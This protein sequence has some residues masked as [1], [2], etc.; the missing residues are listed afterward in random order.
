MA[1]YIKSIGCDCPECGADTCDTGCACD[2]AANIEFDG[3]DTYDVT[4]QFIVEKSLSVTQASWTCAFFSGGVHTG[5]SQI[6][7][8]ANS[9]L[10][11]DSGCVSGAI[12]AI[13]TVPSGTTS[14]RLVH[15]DDCLSECESDG[16][17]DRSAY[18]SC[19]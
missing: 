6:K 17:G 3:D 13:V 12:T 9:V 1:I 11:Y 16:V 15:V 8:Y 10:I 14:L 2:F 19:I 4:G 7:V 5:S 18:F